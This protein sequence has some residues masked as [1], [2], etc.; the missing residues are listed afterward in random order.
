MKVITIQHRQVLHMLQTEGCVKVKHTGDNH[1][2]KA[3][4]FMRREYNWETSPIFLA[5][6]GYRVNLYG[7]HLEDSVC[8]VLDIPD[9]LIKL[10][11][12][13]TW[14]DFIYFL[15]HPE[16]L[17][18]SYDYKSVE[19]LGKHALFD[20]V[21]KI[22]DCTQATVEYLSKD[23]LVGVIRDLSIINKFY[24]TG[25]N[26]VLKENFIKPY[27]TKESKGSLLDIAKNV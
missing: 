8:L 23:W 22:T 24:G 15:R 10:Q 13:Y 14:T 26:F 7:A 3:Y 2:L 19:E 20:E 5:P 17:Q 12:Y 25:G 21:N 1:I 18:E 4:E 6:I 16:E 9:E 27:I 11:K